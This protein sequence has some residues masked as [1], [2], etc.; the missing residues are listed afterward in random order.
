MTTKLGKRRAPI[1]SDRARNIEIATHIALERLISGGDRQSLYVMLQSLSVA[2]ELAV[3]GFG[4]LPV[5]ERGMMALINVGVRARKTGAYRLISHE[6]GAAC[7][8][9]LAHDAQLESAS[10]EI[11]VKV[12]KEMDERI[13]LETNVLRKAA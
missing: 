2:R 1:P 12:V 4:D 13:K 3:M 10:S 6:V 7:E 9:L 11:V 8:A 5:I